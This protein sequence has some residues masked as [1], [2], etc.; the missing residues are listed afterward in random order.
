MN[1][2]KIIPLLD[3]LRL[4]K[5]SD[6]EYFSKKFNCYISNSRLSKIDPKN[7]GS[8]EEF[9]GK[10][11][12][13]YTPSLQIGS[14]VHELS[15]QPDLFELTSI[16]KPTG[17]VGLIADEL[18]NQK[19]KN[20]K[21]NYE[22]TNDDIIQAAIKFDY[23]HGI[24]SEN[25]MIKVKTSCEPYLANRADFEKS[26]TESKELIYL[27]KKSRE[28]ALNCVTAL[29]NNSK[30]QEILHPKDV[31]GNDC[32]SD[33]EQAILLDV[34]VIMSNG[35]EFVLKLK[36]KLD[37]YT[38]DKTSNEIAINDIKTLGRIVS[39]FDMNISRYSYN[40]EIAMYSWLFSMCANKF[41][42]L[43]NPAIKGNYLVVSTIPQYYTKVVP[44]NKRM[45]KEGWDQFTYL[46]KLVAYYYDKGYR[47]E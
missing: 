47:F 26:Y 45:Y 2:I 17:K 9:F 32:I 16:D 12:P 29:K 4:Q 10:I 31:L 5:I 35:N 18:Y 27:D 41:F 34:N 33:M 40:R 8:P 30:V 14:C 20:N 28:T 39:E 23:Y 42:G 22:I 19:V 37:N 24:L 25:M 44:M 46:L 38:L 43:N 1:D 7:G 36:S 21:E 11:K 13:F 6:Q 15:L 3:T